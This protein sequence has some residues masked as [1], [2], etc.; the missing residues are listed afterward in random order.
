MEKNMTPGSRAGSI[1]ISRLQ[2]LIKFEEASKFHASRMCWESGFLP[3]ME[4]GK[5]M[6]GGFKSAPPTHYDMNLIYIN[7]V[8]EQFFPLQPDYKSGYGYP[9]KKDFQDM[10]LSLLSKWGLRCTYELL[11]VRQP[12]FFRMIDMIMNDR[13]EAKNLFA[14]RGRCPSKE[15][16]V[17]LLQRFYYCQY[18][19]PCCC[20]IIIFADFFLRSCFIN[21]TYKYS[22]E[23]LGCSVIYALQKLIKIKTYADRVFMHYQ[24]IYPQLEPKN[25]VKLITLDT[26]ERLRKTRRFRSR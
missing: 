16:C 11:C 13:H 26:I 9:R 22:Q 20:K 5:L 8:R 23:Y 2:N 10:S 14:L 4:V 3:S 1:S 7:G 6:I 24:N 21:T 12:G 15:E 25:L 19:A 18:A 17:Q